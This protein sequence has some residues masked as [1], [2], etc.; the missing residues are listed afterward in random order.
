M[1]QLEFK[2]FIIARGLAI[3]LKNIELR[4]SNK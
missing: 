3:L 4:F 2:N 1:D